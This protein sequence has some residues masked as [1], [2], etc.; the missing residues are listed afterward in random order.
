MESFMMTY[1]GVYLDELEEQLQILDRSVLELEGESANLETIQTIFRA[2][3]TLKGS[4]AAMGLHYLKDVTHHLESVF[5]ALRQ[6]RLSVTP[7]L[8]NLLFR[9][10]DYLKEQQARL[11]QGQLEEVHNDELISLLEQCLSGSA[12]AGHARAAAHPE[13][14]P[15]HPD[16]WASHAEASAAQAAESAVTAGAAAEAVNDAGNEPP[17]AWTDAEWNAISKHRDEGVSVYRVEVALAP[18]TEMP[19]V[20]AML[21]HRILSESGELAGIQPPLADWDTDGLLVKA[22]LTFALASGIAEDEIRQRLERISQVKRVA[23]A[24]LVLQGAAAE[25]TEQPSADAEPASRPVQASQAKPQA[26]V[27]QTVRVDVDRLEHLLNLV[28]ELIIGNTRLQDLKKRFD[29]RF[30]QEPE[31]AALSEVSDQLGRIIAELQAGMMKTRMLPIEN[32]FSRFP[33]LVRDLSQ[34]AG[35]EIDFIIEGKETELDRTLIEEINDPLIH[36][37]RNAADHGLEPP[38]ERESKGKPRKGRLKLQASHRENAIMIRISDD[39]RGIDPRKIK[40]K[41][42]QKGFITEEA[43]ADMTEKELISLIFHSGMSTAE[44]VTELSGRGVGMDIV[45]ARIEK[46]NGLIDIDTELGQGTVFTIKLPLTLAISK[47]LL[48]KLGQHT[49][50]LPLVNVIETFRLSDADIQRV[51]GQEVCCVRGEI[52]PLIRLHRKLNA[53]REGQGYAVM[54]GAADKRVCLF[55]DRLIANQE[56]VMKPLGS[57]L[58][59]VPYLSG[60][61]LLGDGSI[62]LILDIHAV[63]REAGTNVWRTAKADAKDSSGIIKLLVFI[64]DG[65]RY[66]LDIR[67]TKEIIKVPEL[68]RVAS[69]PPEVCGLI[70][71]R[72]ELMPVVDLRACLNMPDAGLNELSRIM[73]M[74]V[75]GSMTGILVDQVT[76]VIHVPMDEVEPVPEGAFGLS[77]AYSQGICKQGGHLVT[78]MNMNAIVRLKGVNIGYA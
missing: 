5:D 1:L 49:L 38:D 44:Q 57:Y 23:I 35:K 7:A 67:E 48:V 62:A 46:L 54:I 14:L 26:Q 25:G 53:A 10:I 36:I 61:T 32:L 50:A 60:A 20:R 9:C 3:H 63:M 31:A 19:R 75:N 45:R 43:A 71:L 28:G 65:E 66:A 37:L 11:R 58:G 29:D 18:D 15:A 22:P 42:V 33:R 59:Q 2:A 68:H 12:S 47:S 17:A 34:Q 74:N 41:A 21:V 24:P 51:H 56:I 27:Q 64:L 78:L 77:A 8:I 13:A 72:G 55:V 76:E 4:S 40:R 70:D 52:L 39:G 69:P 6:H 30:K 16:A 73:I